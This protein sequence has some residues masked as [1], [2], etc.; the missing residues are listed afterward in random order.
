VSTAD[1]AGEASVLSEV[2]AARPEDPNDDATDPQMLS[3]QHLRA[4]RSGN[5][6]LVE[7]NRGGPFLFDLARDPTEARNLAPERPQEVQRLS[8]ELEAA[9]ARL[10]LPKLAEIGV[11]MAAPAPDLDAATQQRLRDLGYLQEPAGEPRR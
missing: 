9:R 1:G 7:T 3:G 5:W 6:K 4:Y 11:R 2:V 8:R 10:G